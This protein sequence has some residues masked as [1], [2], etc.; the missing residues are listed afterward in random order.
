MKLQI[1]SR[2]ISLRDIERVFQLLFV[3]T[4]NYVTGGITLDFSAALNPNSI[5]RGKLPFPA[6]SNN[7]P[8][9]AF[10]FR[11]GQCPGGYD[12]EIIVNTVS[13]TI[14]NYLFKIYTSG[15]T[16]LAASGIPS[17]I[18]SDVN[19]FTFVCKTPKKFG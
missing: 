5:E 13:P 4:D 12:G 8:P 16:E 10:R 17:A 6:G 15:G 7:G 19:G 3:S 18:Y 9:A 14:K 2:D 1:I 11:I